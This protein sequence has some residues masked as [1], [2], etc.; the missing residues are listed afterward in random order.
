MSMILTSFTLEEVATTLAT[1]LQAMQHN[2]NAA[3]TNNDYYSSIEVAQKFKVTK[4]TIFNW[5][6]AN[7]I[8]FTK[9]GKTIVYHKATIDNIHKPILVN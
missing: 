6:K 5:R 2:N 3:S 4:L 1:K 8:P 9:I 7:K